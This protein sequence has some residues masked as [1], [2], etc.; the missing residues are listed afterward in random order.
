MNP[1]NT[2]QNDAKQVFKKCGTCSRTFAYLL[3]REFGHPKENE[4]RAIDPLAGG[5]MQKGQQCG[6]IWG[7]VLAAGAESYRTYKNSEKA[8]TSAILASQNI[9]TSFKKRTNTVN[10]RDITGCDLD[11]FFGM[12]TFMLKT[13]IK[14]MDNSTCFNLTEQWAPEAIQAAKDGVL[15]NQ[16]DEAQQAISCASNVAQKMGASEEESVMVAGFAGGLG[17]SGNGCGALSAAI[18]MRSLDWVRQHP[19]K[20][21]YKNPNAKTVLKRFFEITDSEILCRKI[22]GK[23]FNTINEHSEFVKKGGC[24]SLIN[25]LAEV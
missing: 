16:S 18:W 3:D 17:L 12:T 2:Y 15:L 1:S 14:G 19:G 4:E 20:S 10:C 8:M 22:S 21:A 9:I 24:H 5:I 23:Q 11:S 6:M 13:F 25:Q 7:A